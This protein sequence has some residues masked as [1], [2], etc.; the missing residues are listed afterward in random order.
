MRYTRLLERLGGLGSDKW[1]VHYR[2]RGRRLAGEDVVQ[3]TLGESDVPP[4]PE[5][6][7]AACRA[8]RAGRTL[9][10]SGRGEASVLEALARKYAARTGRP[11][12]PGSA[13]YF[14]GTQ[15]ALFA[16]M[17]GV[18]EAGTDVL[19]GDPLYATYEGVIASTGA[20]CVSVPLR[21]ECGFHL[22]AEDLERCVTPHSRALLLNSPHNPTGAVLT[23]EE[24]RA[25]GEVCRRHDLW[26][27]SDE[28]YEALCFGPGF[29]SPFDEPELAE[30]TVVV[31]SLSKSHAVPGFR[32][33]WCVASEEFCRRLLP[34]SESMLFGAQPFI[35]DMAA[36]ALSHEFPETVTM[37]ESYAR[38]ARLVQAGLDRVQGLRCLMPEAGMFAMVDLRA[39]GVSGELFA[40]RLLDEHD[41]AIMPGEAFGAQAAGFVR[42]SLTAPEASLERG[43]QAIAALAARIR[44][45]APA[46]REA[47]RAGRA[48]GP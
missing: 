31:A 42:I 25:I 18:A 4:S 35:E 38:R 22:R 39:L 11:I 44:E 17:H 48:G 21:A 32:A 36:L 7:E 43:V 12:G 29:A 26:I 15:T 8:M 14:P 20:R 16:A 37:R 47:A 5:L 41:V 13:L 40:N 19:V 28:V 6:I 27:V 2:A 33:G 23:R 1:A 10:S 34:L 45:R 24:I 9:Y 30:R 3:L 46:G